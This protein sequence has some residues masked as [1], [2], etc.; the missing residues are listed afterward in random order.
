MDMSSIIMK[1]ESIETKEFCGS[2]ANYLW[3]SICTSPISLDKSE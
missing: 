2:D 3:G 1:S